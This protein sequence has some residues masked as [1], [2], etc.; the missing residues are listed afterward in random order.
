V[1]TGN[2][3]VKGR[4]PLKYKAVLFDLDGTLLDTLEDLASAVNQGL[5]DLGFPQHP[6]SDYKYFVGWGREEMAARSLPEG[7]RDPVTINR[8][9]EIINREYTQHWADHT[10][11][12]QGIPVMLDALT[13]RH[14][15]LTV[16]TNK[17]HDF[18]EL[19]VARLLS[20][21]HF[22]VVAGATPDMP[23]KPDCTVALNICRQLKM[24][25]REFLYLGDSEID[26]QTAVN[27]GMYPVGALWGFRTAS[28]L[29][30]GGAQKLIRHPL[31][32]LELL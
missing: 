3:S 13:L 19:I 32:L 28:E 6:I 27:A 30:A 4:F 8:L 23:K 15:I 12:Y 24:D 2:V 31:E 22:E 17:P 10:R 5:A 20:R 16:L 1:I 25:P 29:I 18:T 11:P 26:M 21:W 14:I 7:K 9:I